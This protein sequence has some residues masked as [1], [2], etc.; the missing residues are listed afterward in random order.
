MKTSLLHLLFLVPKVVLGVGQKTIIAFNSTTGS[1]DLAS[2]GSSVQIIADQAD[3]PAVL[4]AANDLALDFGRVTG[5]NGSLTMMNGT[6]S[7][8]ISSYN[9]GTGFSEVPNNASMIFNITGL[10][11]FERP[12][13]NNNKGGVILAGTIGNSSVIDNLIASGRI[14]VSAIQGTWEAFISKVVFEPL[15]GVASALVI[16][17]TCVYKCFAHR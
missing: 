3:W 17:G 9:A 16:A 13:Y 2:G 1:L 15:P 7:Y 8:N 12:S 4:R 6:D 10:S 11:S 5:T 14:D